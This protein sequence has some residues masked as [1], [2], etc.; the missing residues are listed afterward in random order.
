MTARFVD[1][2]GQRFLRMAIFARKPL[3]RLRLFDRVE[4]LALDILDQ[5]NFERLRIVE[6]A[7]DDGHL[8]QPGPLRRAP[9]AFTRDDL[10]IVTVR[11]DDDRL[12]QSA[13]GDRGGEFVEQR[14]VEMATRLIGVRRQGADRQH[15]YAARRVALGAGR[16]RC[17]GRH[18]TQQRAEAPPQPG[19]AA[20]LATIA[21]A[22]TAAV[23]GKRAISSRARSI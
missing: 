15:A 2:L 10:I 6:V 1:D 8:M 12:D 3:I 18:L 11:P 13:R 14:I 23:C 20:A 16:D 21:H 22:A 5:R 9:A 4:V 17:L 7:D 19:R